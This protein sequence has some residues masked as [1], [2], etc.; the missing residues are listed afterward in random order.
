[1]CETQAFL[2]K[3]QENEEVA[4]YCYSQAQYNASVNRAYYAVY[5]AGAAL[6]VTK[7]VEKRLHE[8]SGT[9]WYPHPVLMNEVNFFINSTCSNLR[10]WMK[11]MY[12][13]R[14]IADYCPED[15]DEEDAKD[16]NGNAMEIIGKI[17]SEIE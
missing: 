11:A 3:S 14:V 2:K 5:C 8:K 13:H 12:N 16:V 17:R 7:K 15:I 6:L 10:K 1:M 4:G 9:Y